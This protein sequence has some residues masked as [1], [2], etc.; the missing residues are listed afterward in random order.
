MI[1]RTAQ[2]AQQQATSAMMGSLFRAP[3]PERLLLYI[4]VG[5][6]LVGM[7]ASRTILD[8]EVL[9][10]GW[11][12]FALPVLASALV[13]VPMAEVLG[14]K[15]YLRRSALLGLLGL[16]MVFLAALASLA[17]PRE[18]TVRFLL[19]GWAATLWLRQAAILAT[20]H[21]SPLRSL[22]AV[23][24]QPLL[25][26]VAL[27]ILFPLSLGDWAMALVSFVA[28]YGAGLLFTEVAILPLERASGVDGLSMMRYSLDHMTEGGQEG[29]AEM[30]AFF[31][32]FANEVN[33]PV[34]VLS[35]QQRG[36]GG[37]LVV[38][39]ALHPGPYGNLGGSD[40]PAK[41][42]EAL[43]DLGREVLVPHGPSTHDQNPATTAECRRLASWVRDAVGAMTYGQRASRF[44]RVTVGP[45]SVG[46]QIFDG[47][48]LLLATLAPNPTDDIDFATGYAALAAAR[49]E[50]VERAVLVDAHNCIRPGSG[51]VVFGSAE[52]FAV[53]DATRKAVRQARETVT[54]GVR[55]GVAS[56]RDIADAQL[57]LGPHGIQAVTVEVGDQRTAYLLFDGNNMV[58]GLREEIL[59]GVE[60]LADEVEV[61]TSDDHIVNNTVTGFNPVG[62]RMDHGVLVAGARAALEGALANR[63]EASVGSHTGMLEGVRV[64]G[65]QTAVRLTTAISSSIAT[66]RLNATVTFLLAILASLLGLALLP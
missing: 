24:N 16:A 6:L 7:A 56:H 32:S 39:P 31:D 63:A 49:D 47:T 1:P 2:Q 26:L 65:H 61:M 51:A 28:F 55:V 48:A 42:E 46:C 15:M 18:L 37:A 44:V 36:D 8:L 3:R 59:R 66:M 52:C 62:W 23:V 54:E 38:V 29:Q 34:G 5:S 12:G 17:F 57:G 11:G 27:W 50:G 9:R 25:G 33:V 19:V 30:E 13:T 45:A 58:P 40:L 41:M 22:P 14:G 53:L 20:S 4:A 43:E 64:W 35:L 21:S 60:D 10:L